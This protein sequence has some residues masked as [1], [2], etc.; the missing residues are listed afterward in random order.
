MFLCRDGDFGILP[1]L[2]MVMRVDPH[3]AIRHQKSLLSFSLSLPG[4]DIIKKAGV[5]KPGRGS[6]PET[7]MADTLIS[8][9]PVSR[10]VG[11]LFSVV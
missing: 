9:L 5:Y 7:K 10:M 1:A 8:D 4:E 2:D 11:K 6:L 3:D